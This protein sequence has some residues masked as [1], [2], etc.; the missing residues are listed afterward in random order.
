MLTAE[1]RRRTAALIEVV[2]ST[3]SAV[4]EYPGRVSSYVRVEYQTPERGG[5]GTKWRQTRS[6]FGREHAQVLNVVGWEPPV[7]LETKAK[8]SGAEYTTI[9]RLTEADGSTEVSVRFEVEATSV[10]GAVFQRLM[11]GRLMASTREAMERDLADLTAAAE[12]RTDRSAA[13]DD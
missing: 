11:G 4:G 13:A 6:V 9:Y 8:E 2:W 10:I 7:Y 1:V 5:I 3:I 12:L